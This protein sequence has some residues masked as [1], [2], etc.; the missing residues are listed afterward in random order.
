MTL[1]IDFPSTIAK[2][3]EILKRGLCIGVGTRDG[4]MCIEAAICAALDLP[5]GDN[6]QCVASSVRVY[7][8]ALND[9]HRWISAE[10]RAKGLRDLG[11]AQIGSKGVVNDNDFSHLLREE[12]IGVLIPQL[13]RL[14]RFAKY[15]Q[16]AKAADRCELER[17][18]KSARAAAAATATAAAADTAAA[19]AAYVGGESFLVLSAELALKVLRQLNSPGCA[20]LE[21]TNG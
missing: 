2:F 5:H 10:S 6:P 7:K 21:Q 19:Y 11:I 3:D 13:F 8:I 1:K 20:W 14:P 12:T 9:S 18:R 4:R 17:S 15:P 16:M